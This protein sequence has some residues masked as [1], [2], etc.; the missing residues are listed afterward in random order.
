M[1]NIAIQ[2]QDDYIQ[3]FMKYV[4]NHSENITVIKDAN[5]EFDSYFYDRK[6]ELQQIRD[7]IKSGKSTLISFDDFEDRTNKL[8][9]EL[10]VKYAN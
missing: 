9:K 1:Q 7:N 5:L 10:E 2:V 3:D 8:E 6:R 4:N